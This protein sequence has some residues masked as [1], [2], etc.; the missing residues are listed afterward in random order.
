MLSGVLKMFL[1]NLE[2]KLGYILGGD[3]DD[4]MTGTANTAF[5]NHSKKTYALEESCY[6]FN[7]KVDRSEELFDIKS[8]GYDNFDGQLSHN[9]SAHPKV[10]RKTGELLCFGYDM[11]AGSVNYS[12]F[13]KERK[14]I[15]HLNVPIA[16]PRMVHDFM[17]TENYAIIPD[18]PLEF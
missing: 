18:S 6:P 5:C 10:D 8:I 3:I 9:V 1:L 11:M 14:L 16:S 13:N 2:R 15:H 4:K 7:V 17:M 12:L